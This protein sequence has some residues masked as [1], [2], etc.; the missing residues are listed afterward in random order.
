MLITL[1][2][3]LITTVAGPPQ[4]WHVITSLLATQIECICLAIAWES[5]R[6]N[7]AEWWKAD[8]LPAEGE[9]EQ[10]ELQKISV[11]VFAACLLYQA[12]VFETLVSSLRHSSGAMVCDR[13][14]SA[15]GGA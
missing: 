10:I 13:V 4:R 9:R 1:P 12:V 11:A 8:V 15:L 2:L 14:L 3:L 6:D 5:R 7:F